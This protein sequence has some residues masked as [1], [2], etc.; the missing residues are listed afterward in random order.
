MQRMDFANS[1]EKSIHLVDTNS[2]KT[3]ISFLMHHSIMWHSLYVVGH[4]LGRSEV[5]YKSFTSFSF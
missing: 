5:D 1:R 2:V 3:K 4:V